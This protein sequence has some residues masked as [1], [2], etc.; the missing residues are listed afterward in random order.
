MFLVLRQDH[1]KLIAWFQLL[2][3]RFKDLTNNLLRSRYVGTACW[4][5]TKR[6]SSSSHWKLTCFRHEWHDIAENGWIGSA[7]GSEK[8]QKFQKFKY[9]TFLTLSLKLMQ[10]YV[11]SVSRGSLCEKFGHKCVKTL[12]FWRIELSEADL[13]GV[14]GACAP[15]K[16]A[17]HMLCNV[18]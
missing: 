5:S 16:F 10:W 9:G 2:S 17:K 13:E 18:N 4:S 12:K 8:F 6:A 11:T 3:P 15:L 1:V 14:C 7:I